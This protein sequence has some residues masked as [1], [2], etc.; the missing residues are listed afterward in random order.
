MRDSA[1]G[2]AGKP[3]RASGSVWFGFREVT[4][5]QDHFRKTPAERPD[6]RDG[7]RDTMV[8]DMDTKMK[9]P[10][11]KKENENTATILASMGNI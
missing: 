7:R 11:Q 1:A 2:E 4:M 10:L 5:E 3:R 6:G 8:G 9:R